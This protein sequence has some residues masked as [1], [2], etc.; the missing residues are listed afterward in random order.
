[1][2]LSDTNRKFL[3]ILF[4][5]NRDLD[6]FTLFKRMK[7]SFFEFSRALR[8]LQEAGYVAESGNRIKITP[9][10]IDLIA[11]KRTSAT[12][13]PWRKVPSEFSRA[14]LNNDE[15]YVPSVRLLDKITFLNTKNNVE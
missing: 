1:M 8:T 11:I 10:G 4:N 9:L 12:D 2:K 6:A 13:N 5:G 14:K 3:G 15:M 7:I